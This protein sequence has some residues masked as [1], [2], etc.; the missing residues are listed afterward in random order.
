MSARVSGDRASDWYLS[1]ERK[2][3]QP[4]SQLEGKKKSFCNKASYKYDTYLMEYLKT[5]YVFLKG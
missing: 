5:Q 4:T 2:S 1:M 3:S